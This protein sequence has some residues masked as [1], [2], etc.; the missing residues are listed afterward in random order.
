MEVG[1][2][3]SHTHVAVQG[4]TPYCDHIV[5]VFSGLFQQ[6]HFLRCDIIA[7]LETIEI[8]ARRYWLSIR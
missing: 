2:I 7:C 1:K 3:E 4:L 6:Q 8:D 5:A